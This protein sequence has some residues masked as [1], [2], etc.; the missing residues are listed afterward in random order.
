MRIIIEKNL[1]DYDTD[2]RHTHSCAKG[3]RLSPPEYEVIKL[4]LL[5]IISLFIGI[6]SGRRSGEIAVTLPGMGTG[7]ILDAGKGNLP[8]LIAAGGLVSKVRYFNR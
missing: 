7:K 8:V 4:S 5:L 6:S 1:T 3:T 2:T